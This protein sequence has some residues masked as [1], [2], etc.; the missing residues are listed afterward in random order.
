ML[1]NLVNYFPKILHN[2][3]DFGVIIIIQVEMYKF[4]INY[5]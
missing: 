5:L 1:I 2:L 4:I 3:Y